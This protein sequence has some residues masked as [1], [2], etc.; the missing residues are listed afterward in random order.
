LRPVAEP[1]DLVSLT[2][3]IKAR[4]LQDVL[5]VVDDEDL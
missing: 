2:G 4:G 3:Q 1:F 5:F